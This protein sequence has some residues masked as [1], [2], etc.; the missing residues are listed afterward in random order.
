MFT[1]DGVL[2]TANLARAAVDIGTEALPE[3]EQLRIINSLV[4]MD[5][6]EFHRHLDSLGVEF[7]R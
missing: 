3:V 4:A 7:I 5:E 1:D 2:I 6:D